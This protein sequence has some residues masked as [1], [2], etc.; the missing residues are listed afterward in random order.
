MSAEASTYLALAYGTLWAHS[1]S[2]Y[3]S[4]STAT[5]QASS[6]EAHDCTLE[7]YFS[8]TIIAALVDRI[9]GMATLA[10]KLLLAMIVI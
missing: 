10:C 3:P 7:L 5:H 4:T 2:M 8:L 1:R 6:F 9:I